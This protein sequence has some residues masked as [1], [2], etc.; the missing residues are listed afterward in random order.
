LYIVNTQK[1]GV[2]NIFIV[3][4]GLPPSFLKHFF[5]MS[6]YEIKNSSF[7]PDEIVRQQQLAEALK[8]QQKHQ[9]HI[10]AEIR[11]Y[12]KLD[13]AKDGN[14]IKMPKTGKI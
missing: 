5:N 3:F 10:N 14:I 9:T 12:L 1:E 4:E 6:R 7:S 2:N 13:N 8:E 11:Q